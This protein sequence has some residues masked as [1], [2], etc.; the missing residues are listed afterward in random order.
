M[1]IFVALIELATLLIAIGGLSRRRLF[2]EDV[3]QETNRAAIRPLSWLPSVGVRRRLWP[4][5][6]ELVSQE[7]APVSAWVSGLWA[8]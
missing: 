4:A 7:G 6:R 5:I 1:T 2:G 3:T 8:R